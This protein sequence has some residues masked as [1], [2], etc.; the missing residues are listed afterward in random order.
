M[1]EYFANSIF[2]G[3][4]LTIFIYQLAGKIQKKWPIPILNPLLISIFA[5]M[6]ILIVTG[7]PYE[8]YDLYEG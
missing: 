1:Q 5:I 3:V 6:L 4:F 2:F 7:I 8:T